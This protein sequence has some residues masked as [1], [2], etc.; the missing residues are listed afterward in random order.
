M[1]PST[2]RDDAAIESPQRSR[3]AARACASSGST[4][5]TA[6]IE[7][8]LHQIE[9]LWQL[10]GPV[11]GLP[12]VLAVIGVQQPYVG[13]PGRPATRGDDTDPWHL[14]DAGLRRPAHAP[15]AVDGRIWSGVPGRVWSKVPHQIG[16][17]S[18][19]CC[20]ALDISRAQVEML[21]RPAR[22]RSRWTPRTCS[23]TRTSP[24]TCTYGMPEHVPFTTV[25]RA[26]FPPTT[27]PG[28]PP[29]P[30]EVTL[31]GHHRPPTDRG[32]ADRRP[33]AQGGKATRSCPSGE[34]IELANDVPLASRPNLTRTI[35][36]GLDLD[37]DGSVSWDDWSP[38]YAAATWP[39]ARPPTSSLGSRR[40]LT[41][42]ATGSRA[43]DSRQR[44]ARSPDARAGPRRRPGPQPGR[45]VNNGRPRRAGGARP[46]REG[47][48]PLRPA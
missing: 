20:P 46:D 6:A 29:I 31:E 28:Q 25:D 33:R 27:S 42:S 15:G 16:R 41:S 12:G 9:R 5:P 10:R 14:L 24:R 40:P 36:T 32:P 35:L 44:S 43:G 39:T 19:G 3:T 22:P 1:S 45:C 34:A 30:D 18:C 17:P 23:T 4:C 26:L 7:W 47:R 11:P 8:L 37:H 13:S 21:A 38:L 48:R 2:S